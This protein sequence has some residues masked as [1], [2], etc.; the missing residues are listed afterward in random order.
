MKRRLPRLSRLK[1]LG[2]IVRSSKP[3]QERFN[4]FPI[5]MNFFLSK[6]FTSLFAS[7]LILG[8]FLAL[9]SNNWLST[10][11]GLELNLYSFIPLLLQ[12]TLNQE[13]E[14]A[15][16]YFLVQALASTLIL[17]GALSIN[18]ITTPYL[19]FILAMVIKLGI[20]P[21]HFWLPPVIN[22]LSWAI[23]LILAT[24]QKIAPIFLLTQTL[25]P[26]STIV[27]T[28]VSA[29]RAMTGAIGGL[30]QTQIRAILAYSSIGHIGWITA[31]TLTS[32]LITIIYFTAYLLIVSSILLPLNT[33]S[34]SSSDYP[35]N[36]SPNQKNIKIILIINLLSLGGLPPL[37][38]FFPK[39]LLLAALL[40]N[41]LYTLRLILILCTTLNLYYYLKIITSIYFNA[42]QQIALPS[43]QTNK[44]FIITTTLLRLFTALFITLL[45]L[46]AL[47]ILYQPQ[48]HWHSLL[49]FWCLRWPIRH[50]N[51]APNSNWI[52]T[53]RCF[54]RKGPIIQHHSYS[55]WATY[56]FLLS[57]TYSYWGLRELINSSY[58]RSTRHSFPTN[59]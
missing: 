46:Y 50:L 6:P 15:V 34:L 22:S 30:N 49:Y 44:T 33:L 57:Y 18:Y 52:R 38:G 37:F 47:I 41:I 54:P 4:S 26:N 20:A 42:P 24:I 2:M 12:S 11:I 31:R 16:K 1:Y 55:P 25:S 21:C 8:V 23:C 13:K 39:M 10:W 29:I 58:I 27:T 45:L 17:L 35:L 53:T 14:A 28:F 9:T 43:N 7:T 36:P 59:K 56:N 32:P 51:K 3:T 5:L 19:L 48:R 40:N